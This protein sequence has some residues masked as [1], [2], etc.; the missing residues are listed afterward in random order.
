MRW[1]L[2]AGGRSSLPDL[3]LL[4]IGGWVDLREKAALHLL[5]S[6]VALSGV[7]LLLVVVFVELSIPRVVLRSRDENPKFLTE[8]SSWR[9]LA[10]RGATGLWRMVMAVLW[11]SGEVYPRVA[12]SNL[13]AAMVLWG[14]AVA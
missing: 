8:A 12:A 7:V 3:L 1:S 6:M 2:V 9:L 5:W 14:H 13:Y 4:S 10:P 11:W